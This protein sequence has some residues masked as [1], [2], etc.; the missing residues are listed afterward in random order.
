MRNQQHKEKWKIHQNV[1]TKQ[2]TIQ[3]PMHQRNHRAIRKYLE[4][5]GNINIILH[6]NLLEAVKAV[7]RGTFTLPLK[8]KKDLQLTTEP[9]N[10]RN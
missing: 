4:M 2:H 10:F 9:N 6:K 8:T 1:E 5:T 7:V 3:H